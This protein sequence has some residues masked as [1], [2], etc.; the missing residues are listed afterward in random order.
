L[1][2]TPNTV[3]LGE[4]DYLGVA[5]NIANGKGHLYCA[6]YQGG[7]CTGFEERFTKPPGFPVLLSPLIS[8]G[9]SGPGAASIINFF[10]NVAAG[11]L[12]YMV[13]KELSEK[14]A[15]AMSLVF[16]LLVP[17]VL[18]QKTFTASISSVSFLLLSLYFVLRY[19]KEKESI[20]PACASLSYFIHIRPENSLFSLPI[21]VLL[22]F[23]S[24]KR[25]VQND[26]TQLGFLIFLLANYAFALNHIT[27]LV[28][29]QDTLWEFNL[30]MRFKLLSEKLLRE[31]QV[32]F[33]WDSFNPAVTLLM[34]YS[35]FRIIREKDIF[36]TAV[37]LSAV[38]SVM[39]YLS[40][41]FGGF[42]SGHGARYLLST[43]TLLLIPLSKFIPKK[44][45]VYVG[46]VL[47]SGA[48]IMQS[49]IL[50]APE[51]A[52]ETVDRI[53][54]DPLIKDESR[55]VFA[56]C[57]TLAHYGHPEKNIS[58]NY[59]LD[60]FVGEGMYIYNSCTQKTEEQKSIPERCNLTVLKT[61][62]RPDK[63]CGDE[64]LVGIYD[65]SCH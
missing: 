56:H 59:G 13:S 8:L 63:P 39:I 31:T 64:V 40:F 41:E 65:V 48:V 27:M 19:L 12:F 35:I 53:W 18:I 49:E 1:I 2:D 21:L 58:L 4:F 47:I 50:S 11:I 16:T 5:E 25:G 6:E 14:N 37:V 57:L 34:V 15:F 44:A 62:E 61:Y 54:E 23:Q 32:F 10:F 42:H 17:R 38:I 52:S 20:V 46:L 26:K 43:A 51:V 9:I 30:G 45:V 3:Y 29:S 24:I 36:L 33:M 7:A 55:P 22:L 28:P 60:S